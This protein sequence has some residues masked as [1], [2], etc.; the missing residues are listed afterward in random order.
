MYQTRARLRRTL[1][2]RYPEGQG[3]I[4]LRTELD[5]DRDVE[6]KS[7]SRDGTTSTFTLEARQPYLYFKPC[8]RAEDGSMRWAVGMNS[9]VLMTGDPGRDVYPYFRGPA[10]GSFSPLMEIDSRI[11]GRTHLVR[12][13]LPPGYDGNPLRRFPVLYMQDGKN[14]FFPEEAFGGREWRVDEA[15]GLLDAM[16]AVDAAIIVGIHSADRMHDYTKP[17]YE[18]YARSVVREIKPEVDCRLRVVAGPEGT[19]VIGSS[20]G[21]VVSFFMAWEY[22][23]V[24][25]FAACMSSTFSHKDDLIDRVLEE[26]KRKTKFYLDSGWPGDNYEVTLAMAMAL[27]RR[28]YR[29][30]EEFL[31]LVFPLEQ[32]D[33]G[34]WGRRLHLPLQL[35][36]GRPSGRKPS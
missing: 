12:A 33:E 9:L 10:T 31:H 28:G 4:V 34:A 20:L 11:L 24:F 26:R 21:G 36:L 18:A 29:P 13:Y 25:G 15:I 5:W 17:G 6:P 22:P 3:R 23:R 7:I 19:G 8:L 27:A 30:R 35:A 32:H 14:L 1:R 16:G 2:V